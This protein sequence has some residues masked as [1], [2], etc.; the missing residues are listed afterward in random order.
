MLGTYWIFS[1]CHCSFKLSQVALLKDAPWQGAP[2]GTV[3]TSRP[4]TVLF[5]LSHSVFDGHALS[6]GNVLH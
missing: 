4:L 1:N 3:A 5:N 6:L 2:S